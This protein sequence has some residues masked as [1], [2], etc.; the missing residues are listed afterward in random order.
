MA[1]RESDLVEEFEGDA[2]SEAT[3]E[4]APVEERLREERAPEEEAR[5]QEEVPAEEASPLEE[6]PV[7]VAETAADDSGLDVFE[8]VASRPVDQLV[9]EESSVE[10]AVVEEP[11]VESAAVVEE[12]IAEP[13]R[14]DVR[15]NEQVDLQTSIGDRGFDD[16][17]TLTGATGDA[18]DTGGVRDTFD[19]NDFGVDLGRDSVVPEDDTSSDAPDINNPNDPSLISA[20]LKDFNDGKV[21]VPPDPKEERQRQLREEREKGENG[22]LGP[23][24]SLVEDVKNF[25]K[26]LDITGDDDDTG[27][28]TEDQ[29]VTDVPDPFGIVEGAEI[30]GDRDEVVN[31]SGLDEIEFDGTPTNPNDD[32]VLDPLEDAQVLTIGGEVD[33]RE[34]QLIQDIHG[35]DVDPNAGA[36]SS[37]DDSG[38]GAEVGADLGFD[39]NDDGSFGL[40]G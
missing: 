4:E 3:E 34:L 32:G 31:P 8:T 30:D 27:M 15:P 37:A 35:P 17:G 28:T 38:I 10:A 25:F 13:D 18:L 5:L 39:D 33:G 6:A 7:A 1:R 21:Y 26:S 24:T 40:D 14:G 23:E 36:L 29:G 11:L 20:G 16:S 22:G 12:P 19:D 2:R 9:V